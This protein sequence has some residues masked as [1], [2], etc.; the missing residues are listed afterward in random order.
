MTSC[1]GSALLR[2]G[3]K[4]PD[5][6]KVLKVRLADSGARKGG[7][8]AVEASDAHAARALLCQRLVSSAL[9]LAALRQVHPPVL[10]VHLQHPHL[11]SSYQSAD[12]RADSDTHSRSLVPLFNVRSACPSASC[13]LANNALLSGCL[14][15]CHIGFWL[16][17]N[18]HH[19]KVC[20][21][22]SPT[23]HSL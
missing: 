17:P 13:E 20:Q 11:P 19:I 10:C 2:V 12:N 21:L 18:Y 23:A 4:R 7:A 1:M 16:F 8:H 22:P 6:G 5:L 3:N 14:S 9:L 15:A